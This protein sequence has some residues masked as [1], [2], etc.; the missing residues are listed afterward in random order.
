MTVSQR[1]KLGRVNKGWNVLVYSL[2]AALHGTKVCPGDGN[3]AC[4]EMRVV[5]LCG[6]HMFQEPKDTARLLHESLC[7]V[8]LVTV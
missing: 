3:A 1:I 7:V 2:R 8:D 5:R 6:S 4:L